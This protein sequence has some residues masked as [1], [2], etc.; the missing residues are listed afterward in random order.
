MITTVRERLYE[1]VRPSQGDSVR[2][3][4]LPRREWQTDRSKTIVGGPRLPGRN[5]PGLRNRILGPRP[6]PAPGGG[7]GWRAGAA[8]PQGGEARTKAE[9]GAARSDRWRRCRERE[10]KRERERGYVRPGLECCLGS[11]PALRPCLVGGH[12][13]Q[14]A[15]HPIAAGP[16]RRCATTAAG[17]LRVIV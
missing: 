3:C 12:P 2:M 11:L 14:P 5:V 16:G 10:R 4:C 13:G 15:A 6:R 1:R 9:L 8:T 17:A 7:R